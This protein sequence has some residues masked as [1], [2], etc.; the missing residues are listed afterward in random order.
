MLLETIQ[1]NVTGTADFQK[2]DG[3]SH[4][5]NV[6]SEKITDKKH[7]NAFISSESKKVTDTFFVAK[8]LVAYS[9]SS[10]DI[11]EEKVNEV[12]EKINDGYYNSKEFA[13]NLANQ[14]IKDLIF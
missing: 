5:E 12:R 10:I 13:D 3:V 4:K 9:E 11:R 14:L 1:N 2:Y 7:D 8:T 6:K